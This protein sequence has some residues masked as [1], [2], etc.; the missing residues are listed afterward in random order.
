MKMKLWYLYMLA[1][2][3]FAGL[4]SLLTFNLVMI[5]I[6]A[7]VGAISGAIGGVILTVILRLLGLKEILL[8]VP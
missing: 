7:L 4:G 6:A 2:A 1:G 3:L 8:E 5:I